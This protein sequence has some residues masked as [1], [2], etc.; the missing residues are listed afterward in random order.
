MRIAT[1]METSG[2]GFGTSGARGLVTAMTDRVCYAYTAGFLRYLVSAKKASRGDR[3]ALAG[4]LRPSSPRILRACAMAVRDQGFVPVNCGALPTPAVTLWG[5]AQRIPSAMVTGSHIPDDRNGIKFNAPD[6]EILKDDEAGIREQVVELP[7][8][9]D[10][11]GMLRVPFQA[12]EADGAARAH[13]VARYLDFFP[14]GCLRGLRVGVYEHSSVAR[15]LMV[16]ILGGLGAEVVRLARSEVFIPV[17]TEAVRPEDVALAKKWASESPLF[18]LV[19]TDGDSDR[20]LV[21]DEKGTWLRGDVSGILAAK[22][23]GADA[24]VTPVSSN[25]AVEKSGWFKEV[26]RTRIGSPFVIAAMQASKGARVVGYEAN[27]GF[28]LQSP[29]E[30]GGKRLA[31]LPTRD[32]L[33][34]ALSLLMLAKE[35]GLT[36]S[37]TQALLPARFTASDRLKEFPTEKAKTRIAELKS[38]EAIERLFGADFGQVASTDQTD[39]L[40]ITFQ[41]G[42]IV[43]LRASGNAPELRC[44][45]EADSAERVAAMNRRCLQILAGWR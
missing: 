35:R 43:H 6:G 19:S 5:I 15:D 27:G 17:D 34:V 23:L 7:D 41:S 42:E 30:R 13:Y 33:I 20:P 31:P 18:A 16:E 21:S 24:V 40:R 28:L 1:L 22:W 14:E 29:I 37:A 26:T 4:D 44:Y 25:T 45:N 39:G 12:P 9:F 3:V 32:A 2:V 36:L 38:P 10:G 11:A 8:A